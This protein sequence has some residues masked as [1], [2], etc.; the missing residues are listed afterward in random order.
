MADYTTS[1]ARVGAIYPV[2]AID[3]QAWGRVEPLITPEQL[4]FRQLFG[5]PLVSQIKDPMTGKA[6]VITDPMLNDYINRSVNEAE[7]ELGISIFPTQFDERMPFDMAD[8][9]SFG[10]LKIEHKPVASVDNMAI[11]NANQEE[12]YQVDP[13]WISPDHFSKGMLYLMPLT[14]SLSSGYVQS[15]PSN[16][17]VFLSLF[18]N[19]HYVPCFWRVKVTAGFQNGC[20]PVVVNEY[21]G[22]IA[23][24][25]I[26]SMLATTF[27]RLTSTSL[28]IDG[29]S[30]SI[31]TPGPQLFAVRLSELEKER[32]M[33]RGKIKSLF[34]AKVMT[35]TL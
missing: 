11:V 7:L 31:S 29:T 33:L 27:A 4:R 18:A 5:I 19:R 26:L 34:N 35:A 9:K 2:G 12:I 1:K 14:M 24:M 10:Y 28:S 20:I 15:A 22:V 21:V 30:Q 6:A 8:F 13:A 32:E 16:G 25:K 17:A 23:A 3:Q